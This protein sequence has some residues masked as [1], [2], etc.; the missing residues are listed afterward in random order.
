MSN[1]STLVVGPDGVVLGAGGTLPS[2]LAGTPLAACIAL[3]PAVREAGA[4]LVTELRQAAGRVVRRA[5]DAGGQS[6]DLVAV[7]ALAIHRT[8]TDLRKLLRSKLA[9]MASQASTGGL[10]LQIDIADEV[11]ATVSLDAEKVAWAVTTLVGNAVR[12]SQ[13]GSRGLRGRSVAVRGS[14][15]SIAES[16]VIEV[17]DDGP[18]VPADTVARLFQRGTLN[19]QGAGL[20]LLVISDVARAHGGT[21]EVRSSTDPVAHGTTVRLRFPAR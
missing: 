11:P 10:T 4:A 2:G 12:Y 17:Q 18:G 15:D 13:T 3:P 16:V 6:I 21:V 7:E 1:R 20:A 19:V 14:Y 9:V 8:P 5:I